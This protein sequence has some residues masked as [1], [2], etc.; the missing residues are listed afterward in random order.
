[1]RLLTIFLARYGLLDAIIRA[2]EQYPTL[3]SAFLD[4]VS[5]RAPYKDV[6]TKSLR[7]GI[8]WGI[9][10]AVLSRS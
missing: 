4:A 8:I 3:R 10:K 7:P 1:M 2:A 9:L 6:I 5:A